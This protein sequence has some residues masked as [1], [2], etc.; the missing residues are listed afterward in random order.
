MDKLDGCYTE[1]F[2]AIMF[3]DGKA[4]SQNSHRAYA[5]RSRY[6]RETARMAH[7]FSLV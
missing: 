7:Q 2:L 5:G 3:L 4:D 1:W 6:S